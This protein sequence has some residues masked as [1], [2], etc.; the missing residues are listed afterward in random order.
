MIKEDF[1]GGPSYAQSKAADIMLSAECARRWGHK[2]VVSVS[3]NPGNLRTELVRDRSWFEKWVA[4][5]LNYPAEM[6]AW[7]ELFAGWSPEVTPD[8]NGCYIIPWGRVGRFNE[9]LERAIDDGK[10]EVLW[11]VCEGIIEKYM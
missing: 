8:M 6:G 7:T 5:W 3:L 4:G 10:G 11:G 9:G 1:A 2:G